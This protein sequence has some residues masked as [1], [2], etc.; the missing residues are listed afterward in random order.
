MANPAT[1]EQLKDYA[2]RS[3]GSPVIE[4]N[5]A[6]EQLE[7]R[8][9]EAIEYFNINHWNG[10][11]RAY[12]Q[13][14]VTGTTIN[15]TSAV[16]GNFTAGEVIEG[17]TSKCRVA[18]HPTSAGSSIIYQKINNL[19]ATRTGFINGE[20]ITG[21]SSG[22]T[23]VVNTVTKG[24]TENGYVPVTD[25]IF[26]VNKVFTVFSNTTDSRNIFDL[27][28]QLRLND[29]YDLTSTSIVYYTTV[30]GHLSLLDLMLNGKTLYRFNRMHNKLFLDLDWRGDVQIGD[31]I[32]ADV[33]KALDPNTYTKVYG[34]PWLKKYTTALFKKQWG[35][36]LKKFSGLVLPGGV[37][38]DGDGIYNEAMNEIQQLEDELI[39]KGAPLEFFTG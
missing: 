25:E 9:D 8:L 6:E 16:A 29:L 12:F 17:G 27:Q 22:A 30:M 31:F 38:M 21:E 33:Y 34:E 35:L 14:V 20:T 10:T 36:N 4:V 39:G 18:V 23:A 13:H 7:D 32:M 2:L 28:Y 1:R 11:E 5:V 37:S 19:T 3:L 15:L 26:G 24:D